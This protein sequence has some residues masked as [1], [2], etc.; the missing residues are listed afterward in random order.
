M[1]GCLRWLNI[2]T[3]SM[4][5]GKRNRE[6]KAYEEVFKM[7]TRHNKSYV[8]YIA[9]GSNMSKQRLICYIEGGIPKLGKKRNKGCRDTTCPVEDKPIKIPYR[10]YFALPNGCTKTSNWGYGSVAF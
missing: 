7:S 1:L 3:L 9:Y 5:E 8:W 6:H 4:P 2:V 10:L